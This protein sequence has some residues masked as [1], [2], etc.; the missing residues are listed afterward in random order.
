MFQFFIQQIRKVQPV[1]SYNIAGYSF[2]CTIALEMALQLEKED[3]KLVKNLIF[4][5]GSHKYVSVQT[6]K[7]KDTKQVTVLGA[8]SEADAMCTFLMSLFSFEYIRVSLVPQLLF[9]YYQ[10]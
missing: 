8:D 1:G 7:Y 2:G 10:L 6:A 3:K 4:L 9:I 5:D